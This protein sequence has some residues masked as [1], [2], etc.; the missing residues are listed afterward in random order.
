MQPSKGDRSGTRGRSIR[1][2][3]AI[4]NS[5][6]CYEFLFSLLF[7]YR[8]IDLV[9]VISLYWKHRQSWAEE[10]AFLATLEFLPL[11]HY[12]RHVLAMLGGFRLLGE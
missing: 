8:G 10:G 6:A 1:R 9:R 12:A 3:P 11:A 5:P 4:T 7:S 2:L